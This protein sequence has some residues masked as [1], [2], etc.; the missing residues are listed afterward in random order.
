M[1]AAALV[2]FLRSDL[3]LAAA[4][5]ALCGLWLVVALLAFDASRL[6]F[7]VAVLEHVALGPREYSSTRQT[8]PETGPGAETHGF[9]GIAPAPAVP[10]PPIDLS[11]P[12]D[13]RVP[14]PEP[15][16]VDEFE[17]DQGADP[18]KPPVRT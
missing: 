3:G 14:T 18:L 2:A 5:L 12:T 9:T 4:V 17:V 10:Y 1:S 15:G 8:Y 16:D 11:I 13:A 6:R 7:R